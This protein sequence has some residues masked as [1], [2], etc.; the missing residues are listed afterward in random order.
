[1]II[2]K[3]LVEQAQDGDFS[4]A[5]E[6]SVYLAFQK[7]PGYSFFVADELS[8]RLRV[9]T[10]CFVTIRDG[11]PGDAHG[12]IVLTDSD[13]PDDL[14]EEGY[15]ITVTPDRIT[16]SASH[17]A[18]LFYAGQSFDQLLHHQRSTQNTTAGRNGESTI[19]S[20]PCVT[21]QD[22]PRFGWRGFMLDS[23]RHFQSTELIVQLIDQLAALK[24]N[25]LHWH[26]TDD[27]GW[28]LEILGYPK[29]TSVG[30]WRS[31]GQSNPEDGTGRATR[32][33]GGRDRGRYGGYYTQEQVREIVAYA[34][35]RQVTI[36]P[37]IDIPS[38]NLAALA[39]YPQLACHDGPFE[40]ASEWG[41][42]DGVYC[43]GQDKTFT[44]LQNVLTEVAR[45]FP[46]APIHLGGDERKPGTWDSCPRCNALRER[47]GLSDEPALQKWFMDQVAGHIHTTLGRR[48]IT[49]GD[50]I[51]AGGIDGTPGSP[52][53]PGMIIQGWVDGQAGKSAQQGLDT[54]N[55]T[56]DWVYFD[57]PQTPKEHEASYPDWMK[58]LSTEK[59][60]QFDPIP[61]GLD[62]Q[63][64]H[65]ILGSEAHLWTEFVP[66]EAQ[67]YHQIMPRL[68]AF[69]EA[70]WSP[71]A[72]RDYEDFTRRLSI[73]QPLVHPKS[74]A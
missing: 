72:H 7:D 4:F 45:L 37:E 67:L 22:K 43:A 48:S 31:N 60:Y 54:I 57:Y 66:D 68:F 28:R 69:S 49:W 6:L 1:M 51:D 10:G 64:H 18:G 59:V 21:I 53:S 17:N 34:K 33:Q 19:P 27:Q 25:R 12:V 38:H 14:G 9:A 39:A 58:T 42:L 41:L 3:P 74:P 40:V 61:Q 23:A 71:I 70:L 47:Q 55:S 63:F 65:H 8:Q 30:A 44:F 20:L 11:D 46:D 5:D 15:T 73:Q 35:H 26:L 2:P 29:L 13:T 50:N 56:N 16:L 32:E 24:L 62:P 36:I 52:G